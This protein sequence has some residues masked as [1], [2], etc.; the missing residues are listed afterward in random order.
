MSD[1][2]D[3]TYSINNMTEQDKRRMNMEKTQLVYSGSCAEVLRKLDAA[4]NGRVLLRDDE[5]IQIKH[6]TMPFQQYYELHQFYPVAFQCN[7][8]V[9]PPKGRFMAGNFSGNFFTLK[10][11]SNE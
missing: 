5:H 9:K 7:D 2:H 11:V 1:E 10:R 8:N 3:D 6:G 4:T